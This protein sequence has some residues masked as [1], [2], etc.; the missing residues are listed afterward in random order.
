MA[1]NDGIELVKASHT[2]D[3]FFDTDGEGVTL[4]E[5]R[6]AAINRER[7]LKKY[8]NVIGINTLDNIYRRGQLVDLGID[9]DKLI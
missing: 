9:P 6:K 5:A 2:V 4:P 7:L 8:K 3:K 1:I